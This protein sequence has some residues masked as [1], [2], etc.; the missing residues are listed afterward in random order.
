MKRIVIAGGSG[1]IGRAIAC[2]RA[3]RGDDVVIL[4]RCPRSLRGSIR[5]VAWDGRT[6]TD[7]WLR[8]IDGADAVINLAGKNV[9]CRYT[10]RALDEIDRSRESAVRAMGEA[11]NRSANPPPVLIQA[12]T[13]AIYGDR[14]E[15]ICDETS[16][17]G[18]GIP[19]DT[20]TKWERAFESIP[21]LRTRRVLLR[22]PFVLG[23]DGGVLRMLATMA[24]CFLGGTVGNG[25]QFISWIHIDDLVR[26]VMQAIDDERMTGLYITAS[27]NAV[28]NAHFMRELRQAVHRPWSPPVP[29]VMVRL[30]CFILRTEP[31]LA[32]T[33][34]RAFP[35][36]LTELDFQFRHGELQ[37]T[38]ESLTHTSATAR[39][40]C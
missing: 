24:R 20:A 34:R 22:M 1:F 39:P 4:T 32:L 19:V 38:L 7:A 21:T 23:R 31:V 30:G 17:L 33:G 37:G 29:A 9:N 6:I 11:V 5:D 27:P 26:I 14:G 36:R 3:A 40:S 2:A 8:E 15:Q 28:T 35:R 18:E 25:R 12:S 16:P 13:T 10:R